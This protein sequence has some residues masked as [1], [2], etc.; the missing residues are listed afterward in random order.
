MHEELQL[1]NEELESLK[2]ELQVLNEELAL[3]NSVLLV[4][5][6]ELDVAN[7]DILNLIAST[8]IATLFLDGDLLI[9]RFTPQTAELLN[10]RC[11]D[12][13]RP[14][15][16]I[17]TRFT[18][19]CL[20]SDCHKVIEGSVTIQAEIK[21]E[22]ARLYLRRIFPYRSH[23]DQTA[24]VVVTFIDLTD[25]LTLEKSLKESKERQEAILNSAADAILTVDDEGI[26]TSLNPA[27]VGLFGFSSEEVLGQSVLLLL[28]SGDNDPSDL[29]SILHLSKSTS[30][31]GNHHQH[32]AIR[33][34]GSR[35]DAEL[36]VSR[37]NHL[38]LFIVVARDV[39]QRN[40]LQTRI[41][42]IASD[43]QRRIGQELHDGTQQELTGLSLIA[44]TIDEFLA[45]MIC[46][47]S[48]DGQTILLQLSDFERLSSNASKLVSGLK[49][50]NQH[51]QSLSHGI[52]PVQIDAEGLRAALAELSDATNVENKV[53]CH[54]VYRGSLAI[55]SNTV[56]THLY[57]I[58]QEA[59]NNALC[60]GLA[61]EI[62]VSLLAGEERLKLTI[63]DNGIGLD[64]SKAK[65]VGKRENGLGL[66]IMEYRANAIGGVL[67]VK[68]AK[69][70][71]TSVRCTIPNKVQ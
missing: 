43:E 36:T 31:V 68:P 69:K 15:S 8:E 22:N 49:E 1:A 44:G 14:L 66:H 52:M 26:V 58:A 29:P 18:D 4:K 16:E 27:A 71:G 62:R 23:C 34:D 65:S 21:G 33:K 39:S 55:E 57:R 5:V 67:S 63:N 59:I 20:V 7:N 46:E 12:I 60:H 30:R 35:F 47:K 19:D 11:S 70:T 10:L 50:A 41:L 54:F 42:E 6:S 2:T 9:Q 32:A 56:A 3:I 28:N 37:I 17:K 40:E 13:G 61:D 51:V 45:D 64:V 53:T 48:E 25:R 38:S 24:G